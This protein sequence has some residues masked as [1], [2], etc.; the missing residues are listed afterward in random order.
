VTPP[1]SVSW[2]GLRNA[3]DLA[4][5]GGAIAP[6]VLF[7]SPQL[8]GL[9]VAGWAQLEAAG[10]R[11]IVDLRN[12]DEVVPLPLR[13]AHIRVDRAP[14][15]DQGDAD[16]MAVYGTLLSTPDYYA[17]SLRRWPEL[18]AAA[19]GAVADATEGAVLVHCAAG[20]DRTGL[21]VALLLRTVGVPVGPVLDDYATGVRES[22]IDDEASVSAMVE[23]FGELLSTLDHCAYLTAA[24]V[25]DSQLRR[26]RAR[27]LAG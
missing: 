18:I 16:F 21:I 24:G 26:L 8:D 11:T 6:G 23:T 17:E 20:R 9:D 4:G 2:G 3:R 5:T 15:E 13:P 19:V 14:I 1:S 12:D 10:V 7:R 27:L 25:T 22:P